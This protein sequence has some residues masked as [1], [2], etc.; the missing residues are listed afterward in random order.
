MNKSRSKTESNQSSGS[1]IR[2]YLYLVLFLYIINY[3]YNYVTL[4]ETYLMRN[5]KL[6][7]RYQTRHEWFSQWPLSR[8]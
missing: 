3:A 1:F 6:C 8:E 2:V 7:K 4:E 5:V